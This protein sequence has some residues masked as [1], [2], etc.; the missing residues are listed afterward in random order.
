MSIVQAAIKRSK[1]LQLIDATYKD[2]ESQ[3][4]SLHFEYNLVNTK[5]LRDVT[6]QYSQLREGMHFTDV[7]YNSIC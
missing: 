7:T 5:G 6:I 1:I 2:M 4:V 3:C